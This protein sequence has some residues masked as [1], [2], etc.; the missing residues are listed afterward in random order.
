MTKYAHDVVR[1]LAVGCMLM[2]LGRPYS[3]V[4]LI[5]G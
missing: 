5:I 1:A 2:V 3:L 4:G